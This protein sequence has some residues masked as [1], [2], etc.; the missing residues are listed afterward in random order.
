MKNEIIKDIEFVV[1]IFSILITFGILF[2]FFVHAAVSLDEAR[3]DVIVYVDAD[4]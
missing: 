2:F 3:K 1:L 4:I